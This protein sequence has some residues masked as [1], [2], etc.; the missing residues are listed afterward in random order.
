M[1][2]ALFKINAEVNVEQ[3]GYIE[4]MT[5]IHAVRIIEDINCYTYVY[6]DEK[7]LFI[8]MIDFTG[9]LTIGLYKVE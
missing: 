4:I 7:Q 6:L 5:S 9:N 2:K 3:C 8:V 1:D